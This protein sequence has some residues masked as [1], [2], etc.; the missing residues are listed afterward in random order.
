MN[1]NRIWTI[2]FIAVI[3]IVAVAG[4][5]LG[6]SPVLAQAGAASHQAASLNATNAQTASQIAALKSQFANIGDAQTKLAE[7][8]QSIP[9]DADMSAFLQ[10]INTIGATHKVALQSLTVADAVVAATTD[11]SGSTTG[12]STST[13]TST[14]APTPTPTP[15]PAAGTTS[16]VTAPPAPPTGLITIPV[17]MQFEGT[18]EHVMAFVKDLQNGTRLL[19]I[20]D[21]T[22]ATNPSSKTVT[23]SITGAVFAQLGSVKLPDSVTNAVAPV[24]TTPTDTPTPSMTPTAPPLST[25]TPTP[26][27]TPKP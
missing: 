7:L 3:A 1:M 15:T 19:Y 8:R 26:T 27:G 20:S 5:M 16:T 4:W 12:T 13:S 23:G 9:T 6:I 10:E 2:G 11:S 22:T 24:I 17:Q 21:L 25:S 14:P 18:F